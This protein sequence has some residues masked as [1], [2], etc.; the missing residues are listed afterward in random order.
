MKH[1]VTQKL[2]RQLYFAFVYSRIKYSIEIYGACS[3]KLIE[4]LQVIQ[5]KLLKI[6]MG[7]ERRTPTDI[8]HSDLRVLKVKD[9]YAV[10]TLAFVNNC[11]MGECPNIFKEYYVYR[12]MVYNLRHTPLYVP[13]TRTVM[14]ALS[15]KITGARLWNTYQENCGRWYLTKSFK[16]NLT[17]YI[18]GTYNKA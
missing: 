14:G 1:Y 18:Y 4:K 15:T 7:R 2:C 9:I 11:M 6:L 10:N 13:R 12:N 16:R 8:I 5:N 3:N 17:R